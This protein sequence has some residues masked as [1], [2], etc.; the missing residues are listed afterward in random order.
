M[1]QNIQFSDAVLFKFNSS[2]KET[3]TGDTMELFKI[4]SR[5][6]SQLLPGGIEIISIYENGERVYGNKWYIHAEEL[7]DA[8]K[9]M[10]EMTSSSG[11]ILEDDQKDPTEDQIIISV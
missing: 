5:V 11:A 2:Y 6:E 8:D 9:F 4:D 7:V 1:A 10:K 3:P